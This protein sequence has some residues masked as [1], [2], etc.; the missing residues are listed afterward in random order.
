MVNPQSVLAGHARFARLA[1]LVGAIACHPAAPRPAATLPPPLAR[2]YSAS[3]GPRW[4]PIGAIET[5]GTLAVG[6]LTGT[7]DAVEDVR[8]GRHRALATLGPIHVGDGDDGTTAWQLSAGGEVVTTDAPGPRARAMT[9]RWMTRR[10]YFQPIGASYRELGTRGDGDRRFRVVEAVPAGGAAIE[11][12]IDEATGLLGRTVHHEG[13]DTVVTAFDDY[14]VIQG[15]AVAFR[16]IADSGDPRTRQTTTVTKLTLHPALADAAYA[17]PVPDTERVAFAGTSRSSQVP[18]ELIN[19]H[20]YIS[21]R[22]DGAPVRMMVDTG[23]RNLLTPA[24]AARLGIESTGKL[25][26]GGAGDSK[27]DV[28]L[29]RAKQLAVGELKLA[30][31]VFY[32]IAIE[33]AAEAGESFDGLVGFEL[34]E[35]LIAR[36]DYPARTLTLAA[37]EGF[38]PPAG[39]IRVPIELHDATPVAVGSIDGTAARFTIDTGARD[40]LTVHSPFA[41]DHDLEARYRP[42][43]ETIMGWGV[44][45]PARGKPVRIKQVKLGDAAI[46]GVVA[47]L[48]TGAKGAF[49]DPEVSGNIGGQLL[50]RFAVTFDYRGRAMYLEP[51]PA[52]P[53]DVFDRSGM[54]VRRSGDG[55]RVL[56]V[57]PRGPAARAGLVSEDLITAI[58][59]KPIA[60]RTLIEWRELLSYGPVG[61]R[62]TIT[63]GAGAQRR[64]RVLTLAELL[65]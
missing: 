33:G 45:G 13:A 49:A 63:V 6:D 21:A 46:E 50:R 5:T 58:D 62:H 32:V 44:G 12:W 17:Q 64:V 59:G 11:L 27:A 4:D 23:G 25:A 36:V 38:T 9:A 47:G 54:Y 22:I 30:D 18:F 2:C 28:G 24:A 60:S 43:F 56:D 52:L 3:G 31:P 15:V 57:V 51:G 39:A 40:S 55:L 53:R 26:A 8:A 10:G 41:R 48:Y 65:P 35:R 37:R 14:R 19:N 20:I 34:F 61:T 1:L 7:I 42:A 16:Q 29:A